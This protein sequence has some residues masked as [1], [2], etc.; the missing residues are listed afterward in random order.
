MKNCRNTEHIGGC[1]SPPYAARRSPKGQRQGISLPAG[2]DQ[3]RRLWKLPSGGTRRVA[4]TRLQ[5]TCNPAPAGSVSLPLHQGTG[6]IFPQ[7]Q[8][9]NLHP[10]PLIPFPLIRCQAPADIAR[11]H[12]IGAPFRPT[13]LTGPTGP[14][15]PPV[16]WGPRVPLD[17]PDPPVLRFRW[18]RWVQQT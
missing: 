16:L 1:R 10:K 6:S 11:P 18:V 14:T 9:E 12:R 4:G 15:V 2:S 3:R 13:G 8:R 5:R 7:G 17:L